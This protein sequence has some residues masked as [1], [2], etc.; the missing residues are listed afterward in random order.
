MSKAT[1]PL[2]AS[3][4]G[5]S[6][7]IEAPPL[8]PSGAPLCYVVDEEASIRH[9]LSLVLHGVGID[10]LEFPD[11]KALREAIGQ[12]TPNLIFHNISL[13]AADAIET[14]IA[15]GKSGFRGSVQLMSSRGAA[16]LEHVKGIGTQH[17]LTMLPVLKKPFE[18]E[19]IVKVVRDLNL[20]EP[21]AIATQIGLQE[22]LA[23]NWIEFWYQPK[24]DVRRKQLAGAEAY[25]RARHPEHGIVLPSAFM[26]N[27]SK[28]NLLTLAERAV[29]SALSAGQNFGKLGINLRLTV[30]IDL[31]SLLE[32]PIEDIIKSVHPNP[33]KWP[34]LI[35]DVPEE[36]IVADLAVAT[37]LTQRLDNYNVSL[38]ID[39][40]GRGHS[41]FARLSELPFAELK[42][43]RA[44]V[45]DCGTD[46]VNAPICKT[47]IDLAHNFGRAA[48]AMGI[49]KASDA[50]A[51]VSM[52]CDYGQGFLLGQPMPEERF[53]SLLRQR[54]AT[55]GRSLP[56]Q[57]V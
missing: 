17:K 10:T 56:V 30:N 15:L 11:G 49:E 36:Q 29:A 42:L 5:A 38:A 31:Q 9:F 25:A 43:D 6:P 23:S 8:A 40:F 33:Q 22:A 12:R 54:A 19:V 44:F 47:V 2:S 7:E 46:K 28:A 45:T 53:V 21:P 32:L 51:L 34:G 16:V 35:V 4:I 13:D 39:D 57:Q 27:A 37:E 24:I 18:T 41:S 26:P 20:G 3:N 1:E 52:G 55:Q 48:V 50:L 14:M